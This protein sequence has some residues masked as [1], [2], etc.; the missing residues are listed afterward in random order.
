VTVRHTKLGDAPH[1]QCH[2]SENLRSQTTD[3]TEFHTGPGDITR[4]RSAF[5]AGG[6]GGES[7]AVV[8]WS[9][10]SGCSR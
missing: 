7:E 3:R 1:I 6:V 4:T 2:D 5:D 10:A 8:G 9:G